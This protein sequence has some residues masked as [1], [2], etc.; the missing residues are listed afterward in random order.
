M[1]V[2]VVEAAMEQPELQDKVMLEV[3]AETGAAEAAEA[4]PE[5]PVV[6]QAIMGV[7]EELE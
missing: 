3:T 7:R 5:L 1:A 4:E 2:V 6:M